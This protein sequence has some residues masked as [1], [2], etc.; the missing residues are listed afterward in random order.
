MKQKQIQPNTNYLYY[1]DIGPSLVT[2]DVHVKSLG[3]GYINALIF[4]PDGCA[5]R[6]LFPFSNTGEYRLFSSVEDFLNST[7]KPISKHF[8]LKY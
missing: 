3:K 8:D 5:V 1:E 4:A 2:Y 7:S 6:K